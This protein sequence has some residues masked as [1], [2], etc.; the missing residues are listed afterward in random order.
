MAVIEE[1][2]GGAEQTAPLAE[3]TGF[4]T[5]KVVTLAAAHGAHDIYFSFLPPLLPLLME[6]LA[7]SKAEAGLLTI[8]WQGPSLFQPLFGH[9]AD[10]INLRYLIIL[11]PSI[12]GAMVTLAGVSPSFGLTAL[13]L[14]L[15]GFSTAAFHAVVPALIGFYSGKKLGRGMSFFMVGGELGFAIGPLL[16]V[17]AIG[18]WSLNGLPWLMTLGMLVSV[19]L[20]FRIKPDAGFHRQTQ[21]A[22]PLGVALSNMRGVMLPLT[23]V[24]VVTAFLNANIGTFLPTFMSEE[25]SSLLVAGASF[26]V[27]E[28]AA[29]AGTLFSGW[30]SER[31]G[32]RAVLLFAA[33][34]TP[35]FAVMFLY[36]RG[37]GQVLPLLGMGFAAYCS[38][39]TMMAMVQETSPQNRALAN[40]IFLAISFVARTVVTIIVGALADGFGLRAVFMGSVAAYLL[41]VPFVLILPKG[42]RQGE[43]V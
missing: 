3:Q 4:Q 7:I 30:L 9:L 36:A 18:W 39:P 42:E 13:L 43:R 16:V 26:S 25:G 6:K 14:L 12:S 27:V 38:I 17:A 35:L 34:A 8:F 41:A 1:Q 29:A 40:S 15:A 22:L 5:D 19:V 2:S 10:R 20:Y 24:L 11:A 21:P 31:F 33:L 23:G 32:R 37:V 28:I